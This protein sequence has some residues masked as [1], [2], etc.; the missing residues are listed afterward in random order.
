VTAGNPIAT[1]ARWKRC[2]AGA[3]VAM[4][5]VARLVSTMQLTEVAQYRITWRTTR[6]RAASFQIQ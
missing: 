2:P 1:T 5:P 6:V 4:A 3:R